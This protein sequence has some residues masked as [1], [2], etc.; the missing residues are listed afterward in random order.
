MTASLDVVFISLWVGLR[1][2]KKI[3]IICIGKSEAEVTNK[4]SRRAHVPPTKVFPLLVVNKTILKPRLAA[5]M[6]TLYLY[7][8]FSQYNKIPRCS[9]YDI[10]ESNPA[11]AF[12]SGWKANQFVH[13]PISVDTQHFIQIHARVFE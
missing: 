10:A 13:V 4:S 5:A 2:Q 8:G 1:E 7:V 12:R 3:L 6:G 9:T 11:S